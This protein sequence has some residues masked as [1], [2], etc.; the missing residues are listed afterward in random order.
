[1]QSSCQMAAGHFREG[2]KECLLY[3]LLFA[4]IF[5]KE[6]WHLLLLLCSGSVNRYK[7]GNWVRKHEFPLWQLMSAFRHQFSIFLDITSWNT[8]QHPNWS[9]FSLS[10]FLSLSLSHPKECHNLIVITTRPCWI[11]HPECHSRLDTNYDYY[12]HLVTGV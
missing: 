5:I 10:L 7:S 9:S 1:M 6:I 11:R 12:F 2:P 8:P 3:K 4:E